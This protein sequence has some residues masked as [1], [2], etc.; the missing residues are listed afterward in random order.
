MK[1]RN[2]PLHIALFAAL[3]AATSS[4]ETVSTLNLNANGTTWA[5]GT[6]NHVVRTGTNTIGNNQI[7]GLSSTAD[8]APGMVVVLPTGIAG[9]GVPANTVITSVLNASS[10]SLS[11]TSTTGGSLRS[12]AFV[13]PWFFTR[14]GNTTAGS[15]VITNLATTRDMV[16]GMT[17]S[18]T[19]ING[20]VTIQQ[21]LSGSSIQV[22][23][24][25]NAT[26]PNTSLMFV[27]AGSAG[28]AGQTVTINQDFTPGRV[29]TTITRDF[30]TTPPLVV[31][32]S[33]PYT[34]TLD[35]DPINNSLTVNVLD[36]GGAILFPWSS[37][38]GAGQPTT[39]DVSYDPTTRKITYLTGDPTS[40]GNVR[41][42]YT[43]ST[44]YTNRQVADALEPLGVTNGSI[45]VFGPAILAAAPTQGS[46]LVTDG[47]FLWSELKGSTNPQRFNVAWVPGTRS[48][49]VSYASAA[50][51]PSG[52]AITASYAR[53]A[54][55]A[56]TV[57]NL[58]LGDI[59]GSEQVGVRV[60]AL[61]LQGANSGTQAQIN[62]VVG[63]DDEIVSGLN[64][65]ST[66]AI[67]ARTGGNAYDGFKI[68]GNISGAGSLIKLDSG[69]LTLLGANT[70]TGD[71]YIRT[72]GGNT[73]LRSTTPNGAI[74]S[75]NVF[76]GNSSRD[77]NASSVLQL[78]AA[79]Q[80][81]DT[82]TLRFDGANGRFAYFKTMGNNETIGR[83]LD[84][85]GNG[86]LENSE[87][88]LGVG[89]SSTLTLGGNAD[90]FFNGFMRNKSSGNSIGTLGITKQGTGVLT[91][92]GN[93]ISYTG[94]TTVSGGTLRL[95]NINNPLGNLPVGSNNALAPRFDSKVTNNSKVI[96]DATTDWAY[97][98]ELKGTGSVTKDGANTVRI[99]NDLEYT[100]ATE[101]KQG[102]LRLQGGLPKNFVKD[103]FNNYVL[104][105]GRI[106]GDDLGDGRL[107]GTSSIKISG[108]TLAIDNALSNLKVAGG[109]VKDSATIVSQGGSL[110]FVHDGGD[111]DYMEE[112]GTLN[113]SSGHLTV[114]TSLAKAGF[115][116]E[117]NF[118][119]I[120]RTKG[121]VL[122]LEGAGVGGVETPADGTRN[123]VTV[124]TNLTSALS[125][126]ILGGWATTTNS[127][128][129]ADGTSPSDIEFLTYNA[130]KLT[131]FTN[132]TENP[133]S[134]AS[135]T[136]T[137]TSANNIRMTGALTIA[138]KK[139]LSINSL[140]ID[141]TSGRTLSF[142]NATA[143]LTVE[144]GGIIARGNNHVI[145]ASVASGGQITAGNAGQGAYELFFHVGE[146]AGR[147]LT[148][149][150]RVVDNGSNA[151]TVVKNGIGELQL[152]G[153][154]TH[155]GGTIINQGIIEIQSISALGP[156]PVAIGGSSFY[157]TMN[158][159]TLQVPTPPGA[160][161]PDRI[162]RFE[163]TRTIELGARGGAFALNPRT[164]MTIESRI[165]GIGDFFAGGVGGTGGVI[166]LSGDN[167]FT[168]RLLVDAGVLNIASGSNKFS[169][170]GV[171]GGTL[172]I[173]DGGALP[174]K[175]SLAVSSGNVTMSADVALGAISG[176]GSLQAAD[177]AGVTSLRTIKLTVDQE[178]DTTYSGLISD[179]LQLAADNTTLTGTTLDF[180]KKGVG[181]L[182]LAN[183]S[184]GYSGKTIIEGGL[185]TAA[186]L[187]G[188][189][190]ASSI[191]AGVNRADITGTGSAGYLQIADGAGLA[192]VGSNIA[193]SD[194]P[195]TIGTG[196]L[197]VGIYANGARLND[198]LELQRTTFTLPTTGAT[199]QD[200]LLA[201]SA[202]NQGATLILGGLNNGMNRF[203][204]SLRDNGSGA[205]NLTK[206]GTGTWVIGEEKK[207]NS[208]LSDFDSTYSGRTT[209]YAGTLKVYS[210]KALGAAGGPAV[211]LIGGNLDIE[212]NY[213]RNEEIAMMGGRLRTVDVPLVTKNDIN[214]VPVVVQEAGKASWAGD[215][216]L[217]VGSTI[218]VRD[219]QTLT[220]NGVIGGAA[221]LR[222]EGFGTLVL[223]NY[224]TFRGSTTVAEGILRLDYAANTN[225]KLA[226][227]A[228][229]VLGGGR[230]GGTLDIVGGTTNIRE[231]VSSLTLS[232]G[233]NRITRSDATSTTKLRLNGFTINQGATLDLQAVGP[234]GLADTD[235]N[236]VYGILGAWMTVAGTDWAMNSTNAGDGAIT[237]VTSYTPNVWATGNQ[238]DVTTSAALSAATTNSLRFNT[239]TSA[240]LTLTGNNSIFTNG[241]L[242]TAAVGVNS[243][244][245]TGGRLLLSHNREGGN[246]IIN[247]YD[248]AGALNIRSEIANGDAIQ[249]V[250]LTYGTG[251]TV[252]DVASGSTTGLAVGMAV[253]GLGIPAGA[254]ISAVNLTSIE[255]SAAT[256]AVGAGSAL[257]F[258]ADRP[259]TVSSS[260][261]S[262]NLTVTAGS[263]ANLLV[264]AP[265]TGTNIPAGTFITGLSGTTVSIS[266]AATASGTGLT[267][268]IGGTNNLVVE[269]VVDSTTVNIVSGSSQRL[270]VGM[271]ISGPNIPAD[272]FITGFPNNNSFTISRQATAT[273]TNVVPT[274]GGRNGV[275]KAG[276]GTAF[277]TGTNTF[278]G[279]VTVTGGTLSVPQIDNG[280]VAGPLGTSNSSFNNLILAAAALQY[281][282][283][284]TTSNRGIKINELGILDIA[285]GGTNLTLNGDLSGGDGAAF[286]RLQ[287]V[288]GGTL[289]IQR[290]IF[291]G[292]ATNIGSLEVLGGAMKL[293]YNNANGNAKAGVDNRFASTS[294]SLT[295]GGGL[296]ELQGLENDDTPLDGQ[297]F[298]EN[299][300]QQLFGQLTI[301]T[302][303]SEIRVSGGA[304]TTTT[305][306]LQDQGAPVD[307]VRQIGGS[308]NLV[309]NQNGGTA[310]LK[311]AIPAIDRSTPISWATYLNTNDRAQPGVNNFAAVED[312]DAG[313]ISAD[314]KNLYKI[315]PK[316]ED[317]NSAD[318]G[319]VSE[320]SSPFT[321]T[322]AALGVDVYA[323][324]YYSSRDSLVN[325]FDSMDLR[326]GA[327]LI[328]NHVGEAKKEIFGGRITSS[329]SAGVADRSIH[330]PGVV[331]TSTLNTYD[332]L[333][334]NYDPVGTFRIASVIDDQYANAPVVA[335]SGGSIR[336]PHPV[337]F[338]NAGVGTTRLAGTNTYTGTTFANGG[339][340][341]LESAGSLP[342]GIGVTGGTSNL[343][344][345]GGIIG[346]GA[347]G[348]FTRGLGIGHE[349]VQWAGSGGFAAFGGSRNVNLGGAAAA[350]V[351]GSGS[352]VPDGSSLVLAANDS[353]STVNFLNPINL[354]GS[355]R[356]VRVADGFADIDAK[357]VGNLTGLGGSIQKVGEGTLRIAGAG[358]HT[359]GTFL[360]EGTLLIS[361]TG[362]G[363]GPLGVGTTSNTS[364]N[365]KLT[366]VLE[367]GQVAGLTRFGNQ[368][369]GGITSINVSANTT[370]ANGLT[371]DRTE[372]L[373]IEPAPTRTLNVLGNI[374]GGRLTVT[375]GGTVALRGTWSNI[376]S[377]A[378]D[379]NIDGGVVIRNGTVLAGANNSFG[380]AGTVELGDYVRGTTA[381]VD[382][383]TAG[384]SVLTAGGEFDPTSQGIIGS[385]GG[386]GGFLFAGKSSIVIDGKTYG[387]SEVGKRVLV[388][389]EVA[390]PERNGIYE[391]VYSAGSNTVGLV[392]VEGFD[393]TQY[394]SRV[395]IGSG[396]DAGKTV[397]VATVGALANQNPLLFK[398][399][400]SL[401]PNV[402]VLID[403]PGI[404]LN[405]AIDINETNGTGTTSLGG[406][407][408]F[409]SGTSEI[410]G[411]I[412]YWGQSAAVEKRTVRLLSETLDGR[413][414]LLSGTISESSAADTLG[415]VKEGLGI[416]TL[417]GNNTFKGGITVNAGTLMVSNAAGGGSGTGTDQ[418]AVELNNSGTMLGGSGFIAG[419]ATLNAGTILSPGD[420]A[421]TIPGVDTLSFG[422]GLTLGADTTVLLDLASDAD[423]GYD[424]LKVTGAFTVTASTV[425]SVF[426]QFTPT[427]AATFDLIDWGT[428]VFSGDL[429]NALDLPELAVSTLYW[430][431][432]LFDSEGKLSIKASAGTGPPPV[433][434]AVKE[435]FAKEGDVITI[436]LQTSWPA[437]TSIT[438][439][440]TPASTATSD[441]GYPASVTIPAGA[442]SAEV[443]ILVRDDPFTE[444]TERAVVRIGTP[445][446]GIKGSPASL[447]VN[448]RDNDSATGIGET[449]TLRNPL[450]T[451]ETL[452]DVA[453]SSSL[454]VAV[455]TR[456]TLLTSTDRVTWAKPKMPITTDLN[457][458]C[459]TGTEWVVVGAAGI[460]LTSNDG[461][462]W[463][464][465]S[466]GTSASLW[467]IAI[468][469]GTLIAVG[470]NGS[471][472]TSTDGAHSWVLH[473]TGSS[474]SLRGIAA[475]ATRMVA[476]GLGGALVT[477][478]GGITWAPDASGTSEDLLSIAA[479]SD[480]FVVVGANGT[481][482]TSTD[483][484]AWSTPSTVGVTT[485]MNDV[486]WD[487]TRFL[488][489][490][491][492]GAVR[493]SSN[494][495]AWTAIVSGT[496]DDLE[497][498]AQGT[499]GWVAVGAA[500][501]IL[502]SPPD[503]AVWTRN[504]TGVT[505]SLAGAAHSNTANVFAAVG[506]GGLLVTSADAVTWTPRTSGTIAD[507]H[508]VT[509]TTAAMVA[510]GDAGKIIRSTNGTAWT[511]VTPAPVGETLRGV[512]FGAGL[513][514]AVGG[515][516]SIVTSPTGEA[517][518][519]RVS[520]VVQTLQNVATNGAATPVEPVK[521]I[522]AVGATGAIIVSQ[523][524]VDWV[525]ASSVPS[526]ANLNDVAWTGR[527]YVAVGVGGTIMS[528]DDGDNW[529]RRGSGTTKTLTSVIW[530]GNKLIAAG[531]GGVSLQS[532]DGVL[533]TPNDTGTGLNIN[534]LAFS[535]T[536]PANTLIAVGESGTIL[537]T[538]PAAAPSPRVFFTVAQQTVVEG[539][540]SVVDV[541]VNLNPAVDVD[542]KVP[543]TLLPGGTATL[544]SDFTAKV[545]PLVFKKGQSTKTIPITLKNDGSVEPDESFTLQLGTP[546]ELKASKP[547]RI[548]ALAEPSTL[549]FTITN[550]DQAL[551]VTSPVQQ[552]VPVGSPL[553]LS[554]VAAGGDKKVVQWLING[555]NIKGAL[556]EAY[557][558]S[559][560]QVANG[561]R[562]AVKVSNP[563]PAASV[564]SPAPAE[565][566]VIDQ[567]DR[568]FPS[569]A[570]SSVKL[571]AVAGGSAL[572]YKWFKGATEVGTGAVFTIPALDAGSEGD[573]RCEVTCASASPPL[574][575]FTGL[576]RVRIALPPVL[577]PPSA[578]EG[579]TISG[580]AVTGVVGKLLKLSPQ[581]DPDPA[582][583]AIAF[584]STALPAG[585]KLDP[586]TGMI[587]GVPT[588]PTVDPLKVTVT[589]KNPAATPGS[590]DYT[591]TIVPVPGDAIGTFVG[592]VE[593]NAAIN[594][595]H[596]AR[597]DITTTKLGAYSGS[598]LIGAKKFALKGSVDTL[599]PNPS[600]TFTIVRKAPLQNIVVD[601]ALGVAGTPT[602][603][604]NHLTGTVKIGLETAAISG[605]R[606]IW[607]ATTPATSRA[608]V[609]NFMTDFK[610]PT[611]D[612]GNTKLPQG[613]GFGTVTV[614]PA[615][616]KAAVV[617][618]V[619]DGNAISTTA[620]VGPIGE[621]LLFTPLYKATGGFTGMLSIEPDDG[622]ADTSRGHAVTVAFTGPASDWR[623][624]AW[625]KSAQASPKERTYR[626][627]W[628]QPIEMSVAGG[629]YT[630][631]AAKVPA[632]T[633]SQIVMGL[634]HP[635]P[636]LLVARGSRN[637]I[638]DVG[639]DGKGL[640]NSRVVLPTNAVGVAMAPGTG[641]I[642]WTSGDTLG[643]ANQDGS[644]V[645]DN[646]VPLTTGGGAGGIVVDQLNGFIYWAQA[647]QP[648]AGG[649]MRAKLDGSAPVQILQGVGVLD[650]ALDTD[651]SKLY[652]TQRDADDIGCFD[653]LADDGPDK[654]VR[655]FLA[656]VGGGFSSDGI[657]G[658]AIDVDG[659]RLYWTRGDGIGSS[660]LEDRDA[661]IKTILK[662]VTPPTDV[663]VEP[664]T[665][666]APTI[667]RVFWTAADNIGMANL[668][669]SVPKEKFILGVGEG[670]AIALGEAGAANANL[671]FEE[672]GIDLTATPP[673]IAVAIRA[674][675]AVTVPI[676]GSINNRAGTK[677]TVAPKTGAISGTFSL[678]D[679][680]NKR[681]VKFFALVIPDGSTTATVKDKL[682]GIGAGYF[683]LN[684]LPD[685]SVLPPT[686]LATSPILSGQVV[687][688]GL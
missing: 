338:V 523:N 220:L 279:P 509:A 174:S 100:G 517:W 295:V 572:T 347:S 223:R 7:T 336:V 624:P 341:L 650:L 684:Q 273:A 20:V 304:G 370:L 249:G 11:N 19:G 153:A 275:L 353:D 146:S 423:A 177:K 671:S 558:I 679:G 587:S 310:A 528:S 238:T 221:S 117:L 106:Q 250:T 505:G 90:S 574:V 683:L 494:G 374:N 192:F 80:I 12:F 539:G 261:G 619:A 576:H 485:K 570:G 157:L 448:I 217:D 55:P 63:G 258:G 209:V 647:N 527:S 14:L 369:S 595:G 482:L 627:G 82:A 35:S 632:G 474:A 137:W 421:S 308:V 433:R 592:L 376:Q 418:S 386:P 510:V 201:F 659:G 148:V 191:G 419:A 458:V 360:S 113:L 470:D 147:A 343:R 530:A 533:W 512:T 162:I 99:L 442:S 285:T 475:N 674:P 318:G 426:L 425:F 125:N 306:E 447:V 405:N 159:G 685:T 444:T 673:G 406:A 114:T 687:L 399:E 665:G 9:N 508:S 282:G 394:G 124:D 550:D 51:A 364:F 453:R 472:Y 199:P 144:T 18:G 487:G 480:L 320:S 267:P 154:N 478:T 93:Q 681:A 603:L 451:N 230:E 429:S 160:R 672:A 543:V 608:G 372:G 16:V 675:A 441:L 322:T 163:P 635:G 132:Y 549:Q 266:R 381:K 579:G 583:A 26:T 302:G 288:G 366:L 573:Y 629:L 111:E 565:I 236:N 171:T 34:S 614:T 2:I 109:R 128:L 72:T 464:L 182:R 604:P 300:T 409:G 654:D 350:V 291:T 466:V 332:L 342:G 78:E 678:V 186:S 216:R 417:S 546:V 414:V 190:Q 615:T 116:S 590:V 651:R 383:S 661:G 255:I 268:N 641:K 328:G 214:G 59:S 185:V 43:T 649:I 235:R 427:A 228:G 108:G 545:V 361:E 71:T 319:V 462:T 514:V 314:S 495:T 525:A 301:A 44:G 94:D 591:I 422:K 23:A 504:S 524:G 256:T 416:V 547:P 98:T 73:F 359:E 637:S 473:G 65:A 13:S 501:T 398:T 601:F 440:L 136:N 479:K 377:G 211:N 76:L 241:I 449:W 29:L 668:D 415:F 552:I 669:L 31:S 150:T 403:A 481:A 96:L 348:D 367:G 569:A 175:T 566:V 69:N 115:T 492:G 483:G 626:A 397:F 141:S 104:T 584:T 36:A 513:F 259:I 636:R 189:G 17:V 581:L 643:V 296:F 286:G 170:I 630:P 532:T 432:S 246:L 658:I 133:T 662:V 387:S 529:V 231:D 138:A 92:S 402:A 10:V 401:N 289:T 507:L 297:N 48:V 149:N 1:L 333:V 352:F 130:G 456:G 251:A 265:I 213:L 420:A 561:G 229:L 312:V 368:N 212:T 323:L 516:G 554:V 8:L 330:S 91:L 594:N 642:Y 656:H 567:V 436:A 263:A 103:T 337:N 242:Q 461:S 224:N 396:T 253:S 621:V 467:D 118:A 411:N 682:D 4:A 134:A 200:D 298:N 88:E 610:N 270:Y 613:H 680:K 272:S 431:T 172:A 602:L 83:L 131:A 28:G 39:F 206:T 655:Q 663:I 278:T 79:Q 560:A 325:I 382:R 388:E 5:Q 164:S 340:I 452:R 660:R 276:S 237:A 469:A 638:A 107:S 264:G 61:N 645:N 484:D 156:Q 269:T 686:T 588:A 27:Q 437:P 292:G 168:G 195:F 181:V 38:R 139:S 30:S 210:D 455:G 122:G 66:T 652:Y 373:F 151:V 62:K 363:T 435:A 631:P 183:S 110:Q 551:A 657:K 188:R 463:V 357:L 225:S 443:E 562:Y 254:T 564:T 193:R 152:R 666:V 280:G 204:H 605:W 208:S 557:S 497:A 102:T 536:A 173:Q 56:V 58:V 24:N 633:A 607:S 639:T 670:R 617:G 234:A 365:D 410:A 232:L 165:S 609:H 180:T 349:Q 446:G 215:I 158:G 355:T 486:S 460:V 305:L 25:G 518:T 274:V 537:S 428:R 284:S 299:R 646:L 597:I 309:E 489:A 196:P 540:P 303:S 178:S 439:P 606:N 37:I 194:R 667:G 471:V 589:G 344:F 434:F 580:S 503:G 260:A 313:V 317:W 327:I 127:K 176:A 553:S 542:V 239:A 515:N 578:M 46:L 45:T 628:S 385:I 391:V 145:G 408:S 392:R 362:L 143:K 294:A 430:D 86:V 123:R 32:P 40:L 644:G 358:S 77:G 571:T 41:V 316:A 454:S 623:N 389:G 511:V 522:V 84:F 498:A 6:S 281:T 488:A 384:R 120:T 593:R 548:P 538:A 459:W 499:G 393:T 329:L 534:G 95:L 404:K 331:L 140:N 535:A 54:A 400:T 468:L 395:E 677:L 676:A 252:L 67:A 356:E 257:H 87:G 262:T 586:K 519:L 311:L 64:L 187:A 226:D 339:N 121:A 450:P 198:V 22:S 521:R 142:G 477:S 598:L 346:L 97:G 167:T 354:G 81:N 568:P 53:A 135:W 57:G 290:E 68:A 49:T 424:K 664:N 233:Q 293:K 105:D 161:D 202:A 42:T 413:G 219:N 335:G 582:K 101:I 596:G 520:P 277:L 625:S 119:N 222:K 500:G 197:G 244:V 465:R 544:G 3:T 555:K 648:G 616:G 50:D 126:G 526:T 438:V 541:V 556:T 243:N 351:W 218:E 476:V 493:S 287:K 85:T 496:L 307:V 112:L 283:N 634:S 47:I 179:T 15:N 445:T 506:E 490:G 412:K 371:I 75:N 559:A 271:P 70:F 240:A 203:R 378:S 612:A 89:K 622:V 380:T 618:K 375:G 166:T 688:D 457:G 600:A 599:L 155:T 74:S 585:L 502:T 326:A 407:L 207:L 184:S 321:G 248:S 345:D 491:V 60:N 324:R 379:S 33:A 620:F 611:T 315:R 169:S 334:H 247:Q 227:G 52:R 563:V 575:G 245:I 531:N 21:I 129:R 390:N 640:D 577:T 653:L 205:V